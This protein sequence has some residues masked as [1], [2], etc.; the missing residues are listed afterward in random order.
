MEAKIYIETKKQLKTKQFLGLGINIL[1]VPIQV[2]H[3]LRHILVGTLEPAVG[4][5]LYHGVVYISDLLLSPLPF[6]CGAV[7]GSGGHSHT[8][9]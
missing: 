2:E 8:S 7:L 4:F 6:I 1:Q 5:F 9:R 3:L